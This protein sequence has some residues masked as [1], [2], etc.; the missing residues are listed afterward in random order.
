MFLTNLVGRR[1]L[2]EST[3]DF[4]LLRQLGGVDVRCLE[5]DEGGE[6]GFE[7]DDI[8]GYG[9]GGERIAIDAWRMLRKRRPKRISSWRKKR[10]GRAI[11]C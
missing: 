7:G 4:L 9:A 10:C 1:T 6:R 11:G 3:L 5:R 8:G 2:G